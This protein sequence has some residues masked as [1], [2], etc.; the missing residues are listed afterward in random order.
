MKRLRVLVFMAMSMNALAQGTEAPQEAEVTTPTS[1]RDRLREF[2]D[3]YCSGADE[4]LEEVFRTAVRCQES[5]AVS[6][7]IGPAFLSM[8]P[9][10]IKSCPE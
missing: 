5:E 8:S 9:F 4:S 1:M 6:T 2:A 7:S 10:L 3:L